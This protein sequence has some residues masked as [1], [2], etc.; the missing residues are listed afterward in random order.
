M[1][2]R[3]EERK[4]SWR[5]S[6]LDFKIHEVVLELGQVFPKGVYYSCMRHRMRVLAGLSLGLMS[7]AWE[8]CLNDSG[9]SRVTQDPWSVTKEVYGK[10]DSILTV[11][12]AQAFYPESGISPYTLM[13]MDTAKPNVTIRLNG[14]ELRVVPDADWH[15]R[16]TLR[17][18]VVDDSL[19]PYLDTLGN[20]IRNQLVLVFRSVEDPPRIL[21]MQ[22]DTAIHFLDTLRMDLTQYFKEV[23]R[24]KL[25]YTVEADSSALVHALKDSLVIFSLGDSLRPGA[26]KISATDGTTES[27]H[28][29]FVLDANGPAP[30]GIRRLLPI[31]P[32]SF[33]EIRPGVYLEGSERKTLAMVREEGILF[34]DSRGRISHRMPGFKN[35]LRGPEGGFENKT[36]FFRKSA[37]PLD[38]MIWLTFTEKGPKADGFG[39][40]PGPRGFTPV[41]S[42]HPLGPQGGSDWL[43]LHQVSDGSVYPRTNEYRIARF[44]GGSVSDGANLAI[45]KA[46][47]LLK[48]MLYGD[49]VAVVW[50]RRTDTVGSTELSVGFFSKDGTALGAPRALTTYL[51]GNKAGYPKNLRSLLNVFA[52]NGR[53]EILHT[54]ANIQKEPKTLPG[55]WFT[56][57][58]LLRTV[59]DANL[60]VV[61]DSHPVQGVQPGSYGE[62]FPIHWEPLGATS[63][64]VTWANLGSAGG[65]STGGAVMVE[66]SANTY[67][68]AAEY[69]P[70]SFKASY[71]FA[72]GRA[73]E[74]TTDGMTRAMGEFLPAPAIP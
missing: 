69:D 49:K 57:Q 74:V 14:S 40:D 73:F 64:R 3:V 60:E 56:D 43:F 55:L 41:S 44:S 1:D 24:Q 29:Y 63:Y 12:L 19:H 18:D 39:L 51:P 17:V 42:Y 48:A 65:M 22:G 7:L 50:G 11:N 35:P 27:V 46:T 72:D 4:D 47:Y 20:P 37:M 61:L 9:S 6:Q 15:G 13:L 71:R 70:K 31:G 32:M 33:Y 21:K 58:A 36:L 62:L 2:R 67:S 23:D 45:P 28:F 10:E 30:A 26:V 8:G 68:E 16:V 52:F 38:S 5:D 59:I 54:T 66:A 25:Q 34:L 53:L